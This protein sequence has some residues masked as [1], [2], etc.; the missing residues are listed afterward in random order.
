[1][2][3]SPP[4]APPTIRWVLAI[5]VALWGS[6]ILWKTDLGIN[7]PLWLASASAALVLVA[8]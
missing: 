3:D 4:S 7:W 6:W 1:M 8:H 5:A 2:T